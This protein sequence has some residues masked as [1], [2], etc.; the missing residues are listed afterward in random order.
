[1]FLVDW[2]LA[3][4]GEHLISPFTGR[5]ST[6]KPSRGLSCCG[7]DLS[8]GSTFKKYMGNAPID[9]RNPPVEAMYQTIT[10]GGHTDRLQMDPGEFILAHAEEYVKMPADLVGFVMDKS[11]LARLGLLALN[12]IIEPGWEGHITLELLNANRNAPLIIY[13]GMGICQLVLAK[14][15][16]IPLQTYKELQGKYQGQRGV[17]VAK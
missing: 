9:T 2:Q 15:S 14:L 6:E 10:V 13:P 4:M 3:E 8:L 17:T 1:M 12:T 7:Y 11:S 5:I 16:S